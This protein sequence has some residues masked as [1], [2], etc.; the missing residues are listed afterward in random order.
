MSCHAHSPLQLQPPERPRPRLHRAHGLWPLAP[1][2]AGMYMYV[3]IYI[4]KG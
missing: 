3:Y 2:E 4:R 1:R